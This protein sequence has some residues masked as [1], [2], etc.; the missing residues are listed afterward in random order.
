MTLDSR[1][2]PRWDNSELWL[3]VPPAILLLLVG[4]AFKIE[5]LIP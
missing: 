1:S 2:Q 3:L 5:G 4:C